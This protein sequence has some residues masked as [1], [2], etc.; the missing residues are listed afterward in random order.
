MRQSTPNVW[1]SHE[2]KRVQKNETRNGIESMYGHNS[3]AQEFEDD[4]TETLKSNRHQS[5]DLVP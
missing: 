5:G 3:E 1:Q 2:R 4:Q